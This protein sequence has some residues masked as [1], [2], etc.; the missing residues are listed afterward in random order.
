MGYVV[1]LP[2]NSK[3]Q[4]GHWLR[5]LRKEKT[6]TT[7]HPQNEHQKENKVMGRGKAGRDTMLMWA[8]GLDYLGFGEEMIKAREW[9]SQFALFFPSLPSTRTH[10]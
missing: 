8:E 5:E 3:A 6:F 1:F 7:L 9:V 10:C 2:E 4:K